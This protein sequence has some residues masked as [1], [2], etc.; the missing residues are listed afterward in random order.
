MAF[1]AQ[2]KLSVDKSNKSEFHG[3]IQ[4]AVDAAT[5]KN[6]IKIRN[7]KIDLSAQQKTQLINQINEAMKNSEITLK[8]A[9]IDAS[10]A[11]DRL[12]RELTTMLS[13]LS[14]TGLKEF[15]YDISGGF[16]AV[17]RKAFPLSMIIQGRK[18]S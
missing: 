8:I 1:G 15:D 18:T 4:Q 6:P 17:D 5:S 12:R 16:A 13:G 10:S 14:I 7:A 2:I 9:K 3:Q 11:V